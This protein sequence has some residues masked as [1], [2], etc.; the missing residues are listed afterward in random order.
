MSLPETDD[1]LLFLHNPRCSKSRALAAALAERG[2][3]HRERRYLEEPLSRAELEELGRRL[4]LAPREWVR[5][6]EAAYRE[7]GLTTESSSEELLAAMASYPVLMQR[8]ILVA[9]DGASIGRPPEA[10]L[11]WLEDLRAD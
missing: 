4:D 9:K 2:I 11:A 6:G 10:A 8:P 3:A 7:A 1:D 5:T